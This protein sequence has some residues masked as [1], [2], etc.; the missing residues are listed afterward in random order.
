M[1]VYVFLRSIPSST[2]HQ[3]LARS[4]VYPLLLLLLLLQCTC[5]Y[6]YLLSSSCF[7]FVL[8]FL[9]PLPSPSLPP[10]L[11]LSLSPVSSLACMCVVENACMCRGVLGA[12]PRGLDKDTQPAGH[13]IGD[14]RRNQTLQDIYTPRCSHLSICGARVCCGRPDP[15]APAVPL[16]SLIMTLSPVSTTG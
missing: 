5:L 15:L 3:S 1:C 14:M 4:H 6:R 7:P 12:A 10:S 2:H 13:Q 16:C 11:S 9:V 8:F